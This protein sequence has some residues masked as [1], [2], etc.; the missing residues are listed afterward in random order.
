M[1]KPLL[2]VL[3]GKSINPLPIWVM[4]Q[5]GRYLPE[6]RELRTKAGSFMN[7]CLTPELASEVTLQPIRRFGFDAAILFSDILIIPNALGRELTFVE[8]EGPRLPPLMP[9][10]LADLAWQPSKATPVYEALRQIKSKLGPQTALIGF[11]GAPFTVAAYMID[12]RGG[13]FAE[14]RI[15]AKHSP[16][17]L[18]TLIDKLVDATVLHLSNQI[19]AGAEVVQLFDSWAGL[20]T[21]EES[22]ERWILKPTAKIAAAL[23]AKHPETPIIGFPREAPLSLLRRY[24]EETG[25]NAIS[26]SYTVDLQWAADNI[27]PHVVLQGNLHPDILVNGGREL[28]SGVRAILKYAKMRPWIFNLGHGIE[29]ETPIAHVEQ[30]INLV[31]GRLMRVAIVLLNLGAPT[32]LE[33]VEPFLFNLF[34]DPAIIR[35]PWPVRPLLAKLLAKKRTPIAREIYTRL[36]G[37]SPL[38]ANTKEQAIALEK[39]LGENFKTFITMRYTSPRAAEVRSQIEAYNP[40]QTILLPLYPQFSSTTT[41]S[42]LR[43][44]A[45]KNAKTICCYPTQDAFITAQAELIKPHLTEN[46][47]ILFSAHGLPEKI[48]KAG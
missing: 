38:L 14:T 23:K 8:G 20:L 36:G 15:W 37:G 17:A 42:S 11:A 12:G 45:L 26:L 9:L 19:D 30:L 43:D 34:N 29:K 28:E 27:P 5:A 18:D 31:R 2:E 39:A 32:S 16:Q 46:A 41:A 10:D 35:L 21:H 33:E 4:R 1:T 48:V 3:S 22:F 25:V 44:L 7:L 6:Y 13:G 47:R 40:D 24:A